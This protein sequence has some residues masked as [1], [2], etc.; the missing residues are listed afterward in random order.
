MVSS[1]P[2]LSSSSDVTR[3]ETE[4]EIGVRRKLCATRYVSLGPNLSN[5]AQFIIYVKIAILTIQVHRLQK[6]PDLR[7]FILAQQFN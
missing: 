4:G 6:W 3:P 5:Y 1:K 2:A 7:L